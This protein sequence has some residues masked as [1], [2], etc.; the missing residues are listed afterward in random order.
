VLKGKYTGED[1]QDYYW[2]GRNQSDLEQHETPAVQTGGSFAWQRTRSQ[3]TPVDNP[4]LG[5]V[6]RN[7]LDPL[8]AGSDAYR[9]G[10]D[11]SAKY[12]GASVTG[13]L[14]YQFLNGLDNDR[15]GARNLAQNNAGWYVSAGYFVIPHTVELVG[16]YS[17]IYAPR[18]PQNDTTVADN[19]E[20]RLGVNY[21]PFHSQKL[22]L[23]LDGGYLRNPAVNVPVSG[24]VASERESAWQIRAQL[25]Y[26]F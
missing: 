24:V 2:F 20:V 19:A 9:V 12:A 4:R 1:G 14:Y 17:G 22:K 26:G 5:N 6:Y 23:S 3:R 15:R 25:Q 13:E 18:R 7:N 10:S 11:V 8:D 16:G 21:F